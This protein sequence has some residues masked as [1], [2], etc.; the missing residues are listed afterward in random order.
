MQYATSLTVPVHQGLPEKQFLAFP[1]TILGKQRAVRD[2]AM[3]N[4]QMHKDML[5]LWNA[6][7]IGVPE[8]KR[9]K[10]RKGKKRK[11]N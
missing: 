9:K 7:W 3:L 8:R 11:K 2:D 10:R 4:S 6:N 1:D 5:S